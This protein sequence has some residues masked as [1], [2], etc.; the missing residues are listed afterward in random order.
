LLTPCD[1]ITADTYLRGPKECAEGQNGE[2]ILG[3]RF[4]EG[5]DIQ[6]D[7]EQQRSK[8]SVD[9]SPCDLERPDRCWNVEDRVLGPLDKDSTIQRGVSFSSPLIANHLPPY[10]VTFPCDVFTLVK[11]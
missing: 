9:F 10:G 6:K 7:D 5:L 2:T 11:F 1:T 3:W 8:E 4:F